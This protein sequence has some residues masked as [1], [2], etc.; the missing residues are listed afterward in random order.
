VARL[1]NV[2]AIKA[3][4]AAAVMCVTALSACTTSQRPP[5]SASLPPSR[6]MPGFYLVVTGLKVVVRASADGHVTGTTAIPGPGAT[7]WTYVGSEPFGSTDGRHFV[8]VVSR[9]GQ[10]PGVVD[11]ALFRLAV[12]P[13][14]QA[15]RLSQVTF[16]SAGESV[17]GAALSPDGGTLALS[18]L[19]D[20]GAGPLY[21]SVE[22]I[23]L[24][25]GAIRTWTGQSTPRYWPGIPAWAG[26]STIAVPWWHTATA[27]TNPAQ[28]TGIRHLD[29]AAPGSS[30][31]A[32]P[33][34]AFPAPVPVLQSA[35]IA[36]GGGQVIASSC[37]ASRRTATAR[38]VELSATNGQLIRVLRTQNARFGT[39]RA[40]QGFAFSP[41][42]V[43]SVADGGDH[44]LVQAFG[45]G[46]IDNGVFT[47]LPATTP[48][49][50]PVFAAW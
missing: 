40:A 30:L 2:R 24:A 31:A 50:L 11:V 41:C 39:D 47:L 9:A 38:V 8:I 1:N 45:F 28:V 32:V 12:S 13:D 48:R 33:L 42:Q 43:L 20:F 17:T 37:S 49:T 46:R 3:V 16:D 15:G 10:V 14:G 7:E 21:G 23:D 18:L 29:V 27:S 26:N 36:P 19:H 4:A 5:A 35:M 6:G 34:T 22:V 25:D 44:V